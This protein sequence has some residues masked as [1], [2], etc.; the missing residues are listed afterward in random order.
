MKSFGVFSNTDDSSW[1]QGSGHYFISDRAIEPWSQRHAHGI[2]PR[3]AQ[4][5]GHPMEEVRYRLSNQLAK[6]VAE[7]GPFTLNIYC[8]NDVSREL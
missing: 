6:I 8:P 2:T 7:E 4:S 1:K 5:I 3:I